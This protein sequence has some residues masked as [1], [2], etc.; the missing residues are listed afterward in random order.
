MFSYK[1]TEYT[2]YVESLPA[3]NDNTEAFVD[4]DMTIRFTDPAFPSSTWGL[5]NNL[6]S[7]YTGL[8]VGTSVGMIFNPVTETIIVY[9]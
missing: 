9:E 1:G 2:A 4:E 6:G 7:S 5:Y 8:G 3:K